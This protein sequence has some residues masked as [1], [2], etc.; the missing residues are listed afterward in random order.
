MVVIPWRLRPKA[1]A[2]IFSMLKI[3]KCD[4]NARDAS[5]WTPLHSAAYA[6]NTSALRFML[7]IGHR[8]DK[9]V[10]LDPTEIV[11]HVDSVSYGHAGGMSHHNTGAST[12]TGLG[13]R[14]VQGRSGLPCLLC[15]VVAATNC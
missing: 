4:F 5:G 7:S 14:D 1:G 12:V 2:E 11:Y 13:A 10:R 15:T 3:V 6:G 8:I 9:Q